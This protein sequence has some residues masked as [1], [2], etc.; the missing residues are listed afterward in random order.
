M[1][2]RLVTAIYWFALSA[3]TL[4]WLS[5]LVRNHDFPDRIVIALLM[6]GPFAVLPVIRW[7]RTGEWHIDPR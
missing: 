1:K 3:N 4:F 6:L 5:D 7:V 2:R